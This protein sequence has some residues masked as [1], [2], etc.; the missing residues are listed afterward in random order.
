M[1]EPDL[2]SIEILEAEKFQRDGKLPQAET[3]YRRVLKDKP[4]HSEALRLL[5]LLAHQTGNH[6]QGI[7]LVKQAIAAQPENVE[8]HFNLGI[9]NLDQNLPEEQKVIFHEASFI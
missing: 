7:N 4:R 5:G 1:S 2:T 8:A 3:I 9:I 6:K